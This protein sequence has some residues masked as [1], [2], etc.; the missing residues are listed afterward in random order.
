MRRRAGVVAAGIAVL[1]VGLAVPAQAQVPD[2]PPTP[3]LP[4]VP[5][6]VADALGQA[7]S[8]VV[9]LLSEAALAAEPVANAGGFVLRPACSGAGSAVVTAA[10]LGAV[11]PLPV[12]PALVLTP[13]FIMCGASFEPGP[14]DPVLDQVDAAAGPAVEDAMQPV[15]DQAAGAMAPLRPSLS[16]A[17]TVLA[18]FSPAQGELPPPADRID[19]FG[20]VCGG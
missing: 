4:P 1:L 17:C 10:L 16:E 19:V 3:E 13:V 2:L 20:V 9:P 14:A 7:Q 18:L 11:L 8:T 6:P 5:E 15:I 12:S